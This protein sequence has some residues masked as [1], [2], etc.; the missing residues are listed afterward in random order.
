MNIARYLFI[1]KPTSKNWGGDLGNI[2]G[3]GLYSVHGPS[4]EPPVYTLETD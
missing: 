3:L 2:W 1:L 4:I